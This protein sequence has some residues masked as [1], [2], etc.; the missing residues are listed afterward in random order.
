MLSHF[1]SCQVKSFYDNMVRMI[2]KVASAVDQSSGSI[3]LT[4][5][6]LLSCMVKC[7]A[8]DQRNWS[9]M[10]LLVLL[11]LAV[12]SS[13]ASEN[14]LHD[15]TKDARAADQSSGYIALI[16]ILLLS[17]AVKCH[18]ADQCN[19]SI[20]LSLALFL[21]AVWSSSTS[22]NHLRNSMKDACAVDQS[23]GS[24]ALTLVLLLSCIVKHC[25]VDQCNCS[26]LLSLALLLLVVWSNNFLFERFHPKLSL[27]WVTFSANC[28]HQHAQSMAV[29]LKLFLIEAMNGACNANIKFQLNFVE[30]L[31]K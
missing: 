12:W 23:S 11:L 8:V 3:V 29:L 17:C 9:M 27:S 13:N 18:A 16:I 21:L 5:V 7:C 24:I 2:M 20:L 28:L 19:C 4:F 31:L 10:L 14:H 30:L 25:T 6:L 26:I 15:S 1:A 22:E